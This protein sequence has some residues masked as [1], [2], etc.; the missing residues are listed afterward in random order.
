VTFAKLKARAARVD[1]AQ[2]EAAG[3]ARSGPHQEFTIV[4]KGYDPEEVDKRL[5]EYEEAVRDLEIHAARLKHELK[6]ARMRISRLEQS[7]QES[8]DRAMLAVFDAKERILGQALER[9]R[10]IEEAARLSAGLPTA[11]QPD[12]ESSAEALI[13]PTPL[14]LEDAADPQTVMQRMLEEAEAIRTRL[15]RGVAAAFEHMEQMQRAAEARAAELIAGVHREAEQLR[16]AAA[17]EPSTAETAVTVNLAGEDGVAT[18]RP[19]RYS[20][21]RARLPRLGEEG[22][23]SVLASMN[24]LRIRMREAGEATD[25]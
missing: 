22:E 20:R 18:E 11:P 13:A 19:S 5:A 3:N 2:V 23:T 16:G 10:K 14:I 1:I 8:V 17:D 21:N 9:A 25:A 4:R 6:E 24:G 15:D 12:N 7:E